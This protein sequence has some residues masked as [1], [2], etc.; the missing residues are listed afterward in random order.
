MNHLRR[1]LQTMPEFVRRALDEHELMEAYR[2]RPPYQRNDYLA[3]IKRAKRPE[4][5]ARRIKQMLEELYL[6]GLYM[7]MEHRPSRKES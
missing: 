2:G 4:T 1:P 5:R 3:W 6:G 7:G